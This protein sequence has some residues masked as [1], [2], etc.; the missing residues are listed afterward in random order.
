MKRWGITIGLLVIVLVF[1][2]NAY[3]EFPKMGKG[4]IGISLKSKLKDT[5]SRFSALVI[6]KEQ[7]DLSGAENIDDVQE[8]RRYV[9]DQTRNTALKAQVD[10]V[11]WLNEQNVKFRRFHI[12]NMLALYDVSPSLIEK[13][14]ERKD[15]EKIVSNPSV[16]LDLPTL[17]LGD[18]SRNVLDAI[19]QNIISTGASKVWTEFNNRGRGIVVA[20]QDTGI[21]WNHPALI[22]QYR[23]YQET[24]VVHDYN[25]HDAVHADVGNGSNRCGYDTAA[26]CDDNAHGT[27][28]VGTIVGDEGSVNTIG[29]APDAKWIG[30]R[31]MDA[32]VGTPATY[33]ECFEFFLA[34]YPQN[35]NPM[36]D[37][38]T[39]KTPDVINNSWGCPQD[40]GCEGSEMLFVVKALSAA[41][42]MVVV[43]A[44]NDGPGCA[45][46]KD[47]PAHLS[48]DVLSVGAI[49]YRT[50]E[51]ANFSS[52]GPSAFTGLI[53]P[54]LTAPG[55][56]IRS[57]VPGSKY[58]QYG[59]SG[60]SMAGPHVAGA[61]ALLWSIRP[62]LYGKIKETAEILTKTADPKTASQTCGSVPGSSIPNNTFGFGILNIYNAVSNR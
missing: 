35:G 7:A 57:A 20:G 29:M 59:W 27:H 62:E 28:T 3:S 11:Q 58:A 8:K 12:A 23:G 22:K 32:G 50:G 19:G 47:Q 52:R 40:E 44:G 6:M 25:W 5:G 36:M 45:T 17:S 60:T 24:G 21:Q 39:S 48:G 9:Y 41:G 2:L 49:D 51:I 56:T 10:I 46:I 13:I 15:V 38:D 42:V 26:P 16:K 55:V 14:A 54:D 33:I 43:S 30:C 18:N 4:K 34:P 37:G 61:V 1:G 53:G 31:N